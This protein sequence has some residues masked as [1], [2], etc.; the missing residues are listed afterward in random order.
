[1]TDGVAQ[2]QA[3]PRRWLF[4]GAVKPL[5]LVVGSGLSLMGSV[6]Q[7]FLIDGYDAIASAR[8]SEMR[9]IEKTL[10]TLR[11]TQNEYFTAYVQGNLLFALDP[12][13]TS[14]NRGVTAKMYQLAIIDRAFPF[15]AIMAE[16]AIAGAFEFKPTNDRYRELSE[17]ARA[18]LTYERYTALNMFER[19]MLDKAFALQGR[20]Q[21]RYYE[22]EREKAQ[23]ESAREVRR[24]WMMVLTGLGTI[25]LLAANLLAELRV[26]RR[27]NSP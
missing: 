14:R 24:T 3:R 1:M 18:D 21:D 5:A 27:D 15:R 10:A 23:A 17:A 7:F 16:L 26:G 4:S 12:A 19:D 8:A 20:L 22:A 6:G 13:D 9:G 25:L 2:D 11:T